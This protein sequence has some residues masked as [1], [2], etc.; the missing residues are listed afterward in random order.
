MTPHAQPTSRR[1]GSICTSRWFTQWMPVIVVIIVR[2]WVRRTFGMRHRFVMVWWWAVGPVFGWGIWRRDGRCPGR[3]TYVLELFEV[4][5]G[6]LPIPPLTWLVQTQMK[7]TSF[8]LQFFPIYIIIA[9]VCLSVCLCR[10]LRENGRSWNSADLTG[11]YHL[12]P[13]GACSNF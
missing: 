8:I 12:V 6:R 4:F 9:V 13:T 3:G 5:H 11:G 7:C 1:S 2:W 10:Y